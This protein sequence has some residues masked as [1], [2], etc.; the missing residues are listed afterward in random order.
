MSAPLAGSNWFQ[1]LPQ[2]LLGLRLVPKDGSGFS[3]SEAVFYGPLTIPGNFLGGDELPSSAFLQKIK[4]AVSGLA[5]PLFL[6]LIMYV[7][8]RQLPFLLPC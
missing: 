5:V 8:L 6:R 1:H 7:G 3:V 4:Q 2:V